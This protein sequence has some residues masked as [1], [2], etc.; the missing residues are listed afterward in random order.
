LQTS[1]KIGSTGVMGMV[2]VEFEGTEAVGDVVWATEGVVSVVALL[3]PSTFRRAAATNRSS[4][5]VNV[6]VTHLLVR[7]K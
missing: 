1:F 5:R 7:R 6:H 4:N 2:G 3:L